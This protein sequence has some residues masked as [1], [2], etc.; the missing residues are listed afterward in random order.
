MTDTP[1]DLAAHLHELAAA[2]TNQTAAVRDDLGDLRYRA[3]RTLADLEAAD[4]DSGQYAALTAQMRELLV[5]L[6]AANMRLSAI[7]PKE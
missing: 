7:F 6:D 4:A 1:G 5:R 2:I 3:A